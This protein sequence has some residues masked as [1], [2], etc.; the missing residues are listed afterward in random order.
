LEF[1]STINLLKTENCH[2]LFTISE[3]AANDPRDEGDCTGN[4]GEGLPLCADM[5]EAITVWGETITEMG[6]RR[7]P[8]NPERWRRRR[9]RS[10][11]GSDRAAGGRNCR[12][13]GTAET[14]G[15]LGLFN[16]EG[17]Q[18]SRHARIALDERAIRGLDM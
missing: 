11:E 17:D 3:K 8:I 9:E 4:R 1:C 2:N 16:P 7:S 18:D 10:P 6:A 12:E 15:E 5:L 13:R 14:A